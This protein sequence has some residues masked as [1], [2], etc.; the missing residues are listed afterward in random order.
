MLN[1]LLSKL[2][3]NNVKTGLPSYSLTMTLVAFFVINIKLLFSGIQITQT[4]KLDTF[5]GT[6]YAAALAAISLLHVGN[7]KV[8]NDKDKD[9]N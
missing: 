8:N 6:D 2:I 4:I 9:V 1:S 7:K 3:V 5:G